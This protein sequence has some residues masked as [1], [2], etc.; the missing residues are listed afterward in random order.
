M[1]GL[2][3]TTILGTVIV[4]M[5]LATYFLYSKVISVEKDNAT[6][7]VTVTNQKNAMDS[8]NEQFKQMNINMEKVNKDMQDSRDK[9]SLLEQK[10][11]KHDLTDIGNKK[12]KLL[13]K[14]INN[15]SN[16]ALKEIEDL[17]KGDTK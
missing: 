10:L 6:L 16:A 5:G 1:F 2:N 15:A 11:N 7:I 9:V 14:A 17:T 8:M 4:I 12:P 13:E 3:M